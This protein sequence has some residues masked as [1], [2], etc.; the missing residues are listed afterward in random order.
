MDRILPT[1][2]KILLIDD[3]RSFVEKAGRF[4]RMHGFSVSTVTNPARA[5]D[6]WRA[7]SFQAAVTDI[8]MPQMS[9]LDLLPAL[10]DRDRQARII[11]LT[12]MSDEETRNQALSLGA[13]GFLTKPLDLNVLVEHLNR[14]LDGTNGTGQSDRGDGTADRT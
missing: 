12:G 11:V 7:G 10:L 14:L 1:A 5:L 6:T 8:N 4:L 3:D 9:G 13:A 2:P